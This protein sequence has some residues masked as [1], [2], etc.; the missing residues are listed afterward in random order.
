MRLFFTVGL[1]GI[2]LLLAACAGRT[3]LVEY[4]VTVEGPPSHSS[5][6]LSFSDEFNV[7]GLDEEKWESAN[8]AYI[9]HIL[10]SRWRENLE[11]KDGVLRLLTK[12][13]ARA[14]QDW[15]T[16]HMWS[17]VFRQEYGY[18]EARYK[19]GSASGLNNA[20]WTIT[21]RR[22]DSPYH[23]EIDINEG[24]HPNEVAMTLHDWKDEHWATTKRWHADGMDLSEDF[25][26]YGFE[27]TPTELVWYFDGQEIRRISHEICHREAPVFFSTAVTEGAGTVTDVLDGTSMDVDWVR[28]YERI[29]SAPIPVSSIVRKSEI[30]YTSVMLEWDEARDD[31]TA[32]S[33]LVYRVYQSQRPDIAM[34]ALTERN[35]RLVA[36]VRGKGGV[37]IENLRHSC[38]YYLNVVVADAAE[39]KTAYGMISLMTPTSLDNTPPVVRGVP[40]C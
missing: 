20:F 29:P 28:V 2:P 9:G 21:K 32:Q 1:V 37:M 40:S 39:D 7:D 12:K 3:A 33:D 15:T 25:H 27:W 24:H 13:E 35:G 22:E 38:S 10:S 34:V 5:W 6:R 26:V 16:G 23:F 11:V 17:R 36:E 14:G 19:Y 8:Q 18:W 31:A 30:G 4:P